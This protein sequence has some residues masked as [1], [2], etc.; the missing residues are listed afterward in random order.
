MQTHYVLRT[1]N[2]TAKPDR[3]VDVLFAIQPNRTCVLF[4][5][6]FSG[7]ATKTWSEF[8]RLLQT[9]PKFH[10]R[11]IYFYGYDGLRAEMN[12]SAALFRDFLDRFFTSTAAFVNLSLAP[13][14]RRPLDFTYTELV[15]V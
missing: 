3:D 15:I 7:D 14:A 2:A 5:H 12:A 6:G 9:C 10:A 4:I 8:D 13:D 11:D 1:L